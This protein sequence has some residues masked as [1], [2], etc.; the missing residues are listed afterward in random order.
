MKRINVMIIISLVALVLLGCSESS[1]N[2]A[3][4]NDNNET[5]SE[6]YSDDHNYEPYTVE[7]LDNESYFENL[8]NEA[9][10]TAPSDIIADKVDHT[11]YCFEYKNEKP[12]IRWYDCDDTK[13]EWLG[14]YSGPQRRIYIADY[15]NDSLPTVNSQGEELEYFA[16]PMQNG[17]YCLYDENGNVTTRFLS[18][19]EYPSAIWEYSYCSDGKL[20]RLTYIEIDYDDIDWGGLLTESDYYEDEVC[21]AIL[22][23]LHLVYSY[24]DYAYNSDGLLV[25][26]DTY[27]SGDEEPRY[28]KIFEYDNENRITRSYS[29]KYGENTLWSIDYYEYK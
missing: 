13:L 9:K 18:S 20:S 7:D 22:G 1:S 4:T 2:K 8:L 25:R 17:N 24:D 11:V 29:G 10:K 16:P 12:E 6:I 14:Y 5:S 3:T 19:W 28:Y 27:Y 26:I 21:D 15:Q 23:S